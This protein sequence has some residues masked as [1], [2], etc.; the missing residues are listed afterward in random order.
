LPLPTP[1]KGEDK[2]KFVQRCIEFAMKEDPQHEKHSHTQM[3]AMCMNQAGLKTQQRHLQL[4]V[5]LATK[6]LGN[7]MIIEGTLLKPGVFVGLDGVPTKYANKFM[8][9]VRANL[10]GKPIKFAHEISPSS[11]LSSIP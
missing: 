1:E 6:E 3:I 9:R 11:M 2:Q 4:H 8:K 7:A 5:H 10:I